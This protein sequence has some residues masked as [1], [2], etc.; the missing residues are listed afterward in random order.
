MDEHQPMIC[1]P[2]DIRTDNI[3][4]FAA[5]PP[6]KLRKCRRT[7]ELTGEALAEAKCR[8]DGQTVMLGMRDGIGSVS[9][10]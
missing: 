5:K 3:C 1:R 9:V 2:R 6:K 7:A 10:E 8:T 4:V